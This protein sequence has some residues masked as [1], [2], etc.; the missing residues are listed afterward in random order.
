[1]HETFIQPPFL[2]PGSRILILAPAGSFQDSD[3]LQKAIEWAEAR[4]WIVE[5][6]PQTFRRFGSLAGR[7]NE[8]LHALQEAFARRDIDLIW[9]VRGGYGSLRII[10]GLD[11]SPLRRY[12]KWLAGFS[13]ISVFLARALREGIAA[14]HSFMPVQFSEKIPQEVLEHTAAV[15]SGH[16][17]T[18]SVPRDS[19]N[20][21]EKNIE[22]ILAGGNA[23]VLASCLSAC[24]LDFNGKILFLEDIG[25][26]LY[27]LDRIFQTLR[28]GKVFEGVKALI[29]GHFTDIRHDSPPFPYSVKEIILQATGRK[30]LPV[31]FG[32]P[33]GHSP[34]NYPL[35]SGGKYKISVE[36]EKWV[37]QPLFKT[38]SV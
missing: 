36:P 3:A 33:A 19:M 24:K 26:H 16:S 31:F 13:D 28:R 15:W 35:M 37:L 2:R 5:V 21:N 14:W 10:D 18:L 8:R 27:A 11:F 6:H 30:D 9:A 23:A 1:M 29:L 25:E 7:D 20:Q 34:R 32:L 38:E 12:P 4:G 17:R 22:G